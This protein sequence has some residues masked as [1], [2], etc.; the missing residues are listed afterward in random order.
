MNNKKFVEKL[1]KY[2]KRQ[3]GVT[4]SNASKRQVYEALMST[5]RDDLSEKKFSYEQE[6]KKKKKKI[7]YNMSIDF[8]FFITLIKNI[9]NIC[10]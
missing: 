7:E 1:E 9:F 10:L 2:L 4:I 6:L 3:F 8:I 5:V